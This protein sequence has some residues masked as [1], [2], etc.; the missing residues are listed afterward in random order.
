MQPLNVH[1]L[2]SR[3]EEQTYDFALSIAILFIAIFFLHLALDN[4]F[5]S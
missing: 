3:F 4:V 2:K 1:Y 5:I